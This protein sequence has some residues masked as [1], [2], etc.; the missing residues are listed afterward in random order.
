MRV[1][2]TGVT[3]FIGA[4]VARELA[5]RGHEVHA[6]VR[7]TSDRRRLREIEGSLRIWEGGIE[8]VPVEPEVTVH[9]AWYAVPGRYLEAPENEACLEASRRLLSRIGGRLV[10]AGSC[11]EFDTRIG[12]LREDS[13]TRPTTLYARSKDALRREVEVR[14]DSAWVRLFYLYGPWEDP[15]RFVPTVIR[16]VRKGEV[17]TVAPGSCDILHVED[18]ASAIA[19]VAESRL[20]GC[21]NIGSGEAAT[22]LEI[23][24]RIGRLAGRPDLIPPAGGGEPIHIVADNERLRSTGWTPRYTLETGL[25]DAFEW[26]KSAGA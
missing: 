21:V 18:V 5:R 16:T 25:R 19:D 15:R 23:A 4:A 17:P 20:T 6:T 2:L 10:A 22:F 11:F 26:W 3:G 24:A 12:R 8:T 14:P 7:A 1:L 9:L 13:P